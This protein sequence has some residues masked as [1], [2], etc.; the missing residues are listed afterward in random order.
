MAIFWDI[1]LIAEVALNGTVR[2]LVSVLNIME[3]ISITISL[4]QWDYKS[5]WEGRSLPIL[6][7]AAV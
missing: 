2:T 4:K 7:T 6:M 1:L 3:I 5:F